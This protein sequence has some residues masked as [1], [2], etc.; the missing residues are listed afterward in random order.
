[1]PYAMWVT[2]FNFLY[3]QC[4]NCLIW[5]LWYGKLS[6]YVPG[7]TQHTS[8]FWLDIISVGYIGQKTEFYSNQIT[9]KELF[10]VKST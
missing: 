9:E 2:I 3:D 4:G 7:R 1:M 10:P 5:W 8:N 6:F